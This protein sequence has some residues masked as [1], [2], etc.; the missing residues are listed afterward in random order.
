MLALALISR[1]VRHVSGPCG[2][3]TD[4]VY[5]RRS[6][7]TATVLPDRAATYRDFGELDLRR[8]RLGGHP[9]ALPGKEFG[10]IAEVLQP[11]SFKVPGF[12]EPLDTSDTPSAT[13]PEPRTL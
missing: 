12:I 6:A 7:T 10:G 5:R 1:P 9:P 2:I 4:L 8:A 11:S 3:G 13:T